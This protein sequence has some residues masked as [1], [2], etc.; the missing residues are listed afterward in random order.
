MNRS[1]QHTPSPLAEILWHRG[2]PC[3]SKSI[4][5]PPQSTHQP[6]KALAPAPTTVVSHFEMCVE[7]ELNNKTRRLWGV[8]WNWSFA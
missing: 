3:P 4:T 7:E 1:R 8:T 6:C 5:F 2:I